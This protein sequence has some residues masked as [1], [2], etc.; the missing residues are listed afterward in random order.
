M[1]KVTRLEKAQQSLAANIQKVLQGVYV[2][3]M[4]C[5]VDSWQRG[6]SASAGSCYIYTYGYMYKCTRLNFTYFADF[7]AG[8]NI[9]HAEVQFSPGLWDQGKEES[10]EGTGSV[11]EFGAG[12]MG[13]GAWN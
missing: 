6:I 8:Q 13:G 3:S 7:L 9:H 11:M 5:C 10:R 1:G 4:S 12:G 2:Y